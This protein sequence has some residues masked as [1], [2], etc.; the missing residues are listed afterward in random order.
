MASYP[1]LKDI[2]IINNKFMYDIDTIEWN[3]Q[4]ACLS[5]RVLLRNQRLTP[6]ICAKYV[7]FGGRNG[8]YADCCEDSWISVGEVLNYQSHITM[9][10]MIEARKI[11][12]EEYERE[13]KE[14]KKMVE[15][16]AWV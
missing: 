1:L 6:Y 7:V 8:Q 3:I 9:E 16:E 11:V 5:L 14:R 15:E 2:D 13:E 10:D 4:N 12:K